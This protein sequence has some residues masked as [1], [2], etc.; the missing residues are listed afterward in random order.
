[1]VFSRINFEAR[2]IK[3]S[4]CRKIIESTDNVNTSKL[5]TLD[6]NDTKE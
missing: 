4:Q 1:M 3:K 5:S 6:E 2:E